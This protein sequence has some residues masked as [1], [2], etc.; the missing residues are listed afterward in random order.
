[1]PVRGSSILKNSSISPFKPSH[2]SFSCAVLPKGVA[3]VSHQL[4][5]NVGKKS[6]I[7]ALVVTDLLSKI[8]NLL[9]YATAAG[10]VRK[11][12]M[13]GNEWFRRQE[14]KFLLKPDFEKFVYMYFHV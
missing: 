14:D 1:L 13:A 11:A 2:P 8:R 6:L 12:F 10:V 3:I 7:W 5:N 4:V 9:N